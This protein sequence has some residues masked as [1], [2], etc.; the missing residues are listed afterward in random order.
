MA[1]A[2]RKN[3][4]Q[5]SATLAALFTSIPS[6][7]T[8]LSASSNRRDQSSCLSTKSI[9][10]MAA[11][12]GFVRMPGW[13]GVR[14]QMSIEPG[15]VADAVREA[16]DL[17][18]PLAAERDMELSAPA[19]DDESV[20]VLADRQRF[21]QVLLNLLTNANKYTPPGGKVGVSFAASVN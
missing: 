10:R 21:K 11:R 2:H 5:A 12:F 1:T 20:Y 3:S 14:I 18:R 17:I 4:W 7:A 13:S 6:A 16:L 9:A 8:T 19:A 15:C